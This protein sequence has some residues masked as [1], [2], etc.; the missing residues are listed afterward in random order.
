M[1]W[2]AD[3][4]VNPGTYEW[5]AEDQSAN[6]LGTMGESADGTIAECT[7]DTGAAANCTFTVAADGSVSGI[8]KIHYMM[9]SAS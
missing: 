7:D 4:T 3:V 9:P 5:G 6:W 8:M 1:M 2:S